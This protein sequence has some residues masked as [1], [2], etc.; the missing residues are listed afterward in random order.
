MHCSNI[1]CSQKLSWLRQCCSSVRVVWR[2]SCLAIGRLWNANRKEGGKVAPRREMTSENT[3]FN[4]I[5]TKFAW[6]Q[7]LQVQGQKDVHCYYSRIDSHSSVKTKLRSE[8]ILDKCKLQI[9]LNILQHSGQG[10]QKNVGRLCLSDLV[11]SSGRFLI[12]KPQIRIVRTW[13]KPPW[14]F[15][16]RTRFLSHRDN[17]SFQQLDLEPP[18]AA[19]LP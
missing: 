19:S 2:R 1:H 16:V 5:T 9:L 11:R 7:I 3:K 14:Q 10:R 13:F 12:G 18:V 15:L 17:S 8:W 6:R 4:Q